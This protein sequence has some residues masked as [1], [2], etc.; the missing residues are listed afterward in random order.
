[1]MQLYTQDN[2]IQQEKLIKLLWKKL[3]L[4]V[5]GFMWT[6]DL[7]FRLNIMFCAIQ[8]AQKDALLHHIHHQR[9][10]QCRTNV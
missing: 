2:H 5:V 4:Y 9:H 6:V 10:H 3:L 7:L 1:M 8:P